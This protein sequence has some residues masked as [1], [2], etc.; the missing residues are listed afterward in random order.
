[1][2][3]KLSDGN[4]IDTEKLND[5]EAMIMEK[6]KELSEISETYKVPFY[7][8]MTLDNKPMSV[9]NFVNKEK[10]LEL[11]GYTA[12]NF[13]RITNGAVKFVAIVQD[14][15]EDKEEFPNEDL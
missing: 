12:Y 1:M 10:C 13:S 7:C 6:F 14:D 8:A 15:E 3:I 4:T 2:I 11:I 9:H 5:I